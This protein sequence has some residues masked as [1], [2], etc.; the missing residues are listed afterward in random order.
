MGWRERNQQIDE[1][2]VSE[3]ALFI[4]VNFLLV[5]RLIEDLE[6]ILAVFKLD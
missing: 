1:A 6:L 5:L 4:A 2:S 3:N